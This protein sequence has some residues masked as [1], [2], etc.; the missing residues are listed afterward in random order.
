MRSE[1]RERVRGFKA[2][3]CDSG[4]FGYTSPGG[5]QLT[6]VGVFRL[7]RLGEPSCAEVNS[8]GAPESAMVM[9]N[10]V[11]RGQFAGQ[12]GVRVE[13]CSAL[14]GIYHVYVRSRSRAVALHAIER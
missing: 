9:E 4:G 13:F 5:G 1:T 11:R 7:R 2:N 6:G 10:E 8:T 12:L 14:V 3:A